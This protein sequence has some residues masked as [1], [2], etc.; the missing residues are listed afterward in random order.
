MEEVA[1][2]HRVAAAVGRRTVG[3]LAGT[4]QEAETRIEELHIEERHKG[5]LVEAAAGTHTHLVLG[6]EGPDS[7]NHP[8]E[9]ADKTLCA[10]RNMN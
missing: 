6:E 4:A 8:L 7:H 9:G 2:N 5:Q 1:G 10:P 3:E